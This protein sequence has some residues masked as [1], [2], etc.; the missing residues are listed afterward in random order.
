MGLY[1]KHLQN[2]SKEECAL[3]HSSLTSLSAART[4]RYEIPN[5]RRVVG[6][7]IR[8]YPN[9]IGKKYPT[10]VEIRFVVHAMLDKDPSGTTIYYKEEFF[11]TEISVSE[12]NL[13]IEERKLILQALNQ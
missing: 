3:A 5:E 10:R 2:E 7:T 11:I 9:S 6:R 12:N 1:I 4:E 13:N 8:V